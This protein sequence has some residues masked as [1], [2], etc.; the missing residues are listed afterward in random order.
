MHK[1]KTPN[2]KV[3]VTLRSQRSE[4][5]KVGGYDGEQVSAVSKPN[6]NIIGKYL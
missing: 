2:C 4:V 6:V 5:R 3:M 1:T